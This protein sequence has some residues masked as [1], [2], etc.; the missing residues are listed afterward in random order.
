MKNN[1]KDGDKPWTAVSSIEQKF[2][3]IKMDNSDWNIWGSP[4]GTF[5]SDYLDQ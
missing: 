4:V 2:H 1:I 3:G 5:E